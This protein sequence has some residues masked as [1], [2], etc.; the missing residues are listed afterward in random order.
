MK[1]LYMIPSLLILF[2]ALNA[3]A[4]NSLL[5]NVASENCQHGVR[6]LEHSDY[7]IFIFCDGAL[8]T[9]IGIILSRRG[10]YPTDSSKPNLWGTT[11]RFW[12]DGIWA[13]DIQDVLWSPS[14]DYLY[15]STSGIYGDGGLFE[16]DLLQKKYSRIFPESWQDKDNSIIFTRIESY[17]AKS[18]KI[19]VGL[20]SVESNKRIRK[21]ALPIK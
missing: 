18:R 20:Y 12:Q 4:D 21:V 9:N 19:N 14:G 11:N 13:T 7:S 10:V 15:I 3:Q 2:G 5:I 8:G 17:H 16:L 6:S 1:N